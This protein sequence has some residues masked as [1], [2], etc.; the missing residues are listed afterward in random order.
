[1][2]VLLAHNTYLQPGG[3]DV[4]FRAD[5]S[6]LREHGHDV[7]AHL[8]HNEEIAAMGSIEL[9]RKTL[10]NAQT[11]SKLAEMIG[12]H[13]PDVIHLH[14]TFP[15]LSPSVAATGRAL[16][17]PVVQTL[18]NYRLICPNAQ[19]SRDGH[20]C[21]DCLG[22]FAPWPGVVHGC[23]RGSRSATSVVLLSVIEQRLLRRM[24]RS[25]HLY[26]ALTETARQQFIGEGFQPDRI[27]VRS[28]FLV[29]DPG[30]GDGSGGYALFA[31]RLSPEKGVRTLLDAWSRVDKPITLKIAGD[32]PLRSAVAAAAEAIPS[33]D[34]LGWQDRNEIIDLLKGASVLI[35]PSVWSE[36]MP[37]VVVESFAVGTPVIASRLG[38]L[39]EMIHDGE[40]GVHFTPGDPADLARA[41]R[42][43]IT[44]QGLL[45][46]MRGAARQNFEQR[47]TADRA[48]ARLI[49][50]YKS[51]RRAVA[52]V[53]AM[54][55]PAQSVTDD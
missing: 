35:V 19:L 41:V 7:R 30:E 16:G 13:R 12:R 39:H 46:T 5:V 8:M 37:Q 26:I 3:E 51:A 21:S 6:L 33:I 54:H 53:V 4:A 22:R 11:S 2:H 45:A 25:A 23:Y 14:N 36:G 32:G 55:R 10:W 38:A 44:N 52:P 34:Y 40:T 47:Y 15:L 31:G 17:V 42:H 48:Y 24:G 18:H 20:S 50:I 43:L 9:A 27:V 29:T 1:M 28:N 49:E